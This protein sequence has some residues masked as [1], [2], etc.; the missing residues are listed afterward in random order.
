MDLS[1][2]NLKPH[3]LFQHLDEVI[4]WRDG[5]Y[6]APIFVEL[7]PIDVCNQ[8]CHFCYTEYMGHQ[9]LA[10]AEDLLVKIFEDLG[11]EGVK[12]V[13]IQ[14]TGE[15]LLNQ[16]LPE[17][18]LRGRSAGLD[19]ALCTNGVL[20]EPQVTERILSSL[21]WVRVSAIESQPSVYAKTH[22]CSE[23]HW[24][25]VVENIKRMVKAR[26]EGGLETVLAC[27]Y[28]PFPYNAKYVYDVVSMCRDLGMDYIQ[29][30]PAFV[31]LHNPS[32][33]WDRDTY[34]QFRELFEKAS[35]LQT[36]DF[37]VDIRWDQF[38][39]QK[40]EGPFPKS[41]RCC[42]GMEFETMIDSDSCVYPC[43]NFWRDEA[44]RIGDLKEMGFGEIWRSERR[45][46]VLDGIY[47]DY[48]LGK[49]HFGC[50][51]HHINITLWELANPPM[52]KNFL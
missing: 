20:L 38:E 42:Y 15:P 18:I 13:Q 19:L 28:I 29:I 3:K 49:C 12:A 48:E 39:R 8:R 2:L 6:F 16:A 25:R 34:L 41:Y 45:R 11:E 50:K 30:K 52:H 14:G 35:A 5:K 40:D 17:A 21:S 51:H 22:G 31:S 24:H 46:Q 43:L 9:R 36:G 10:I 32:H 26:E 33:A 1:R 27:H 7:S 4:K 47:A 23:W 44:H 37:L